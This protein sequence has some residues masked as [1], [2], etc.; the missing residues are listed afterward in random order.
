MTAVGVTADGSLEVSE[1]A[2]LDAAGHDGEVET[3]ADQQVNEQFTP[4]QAV[5]D[6]DGIVEPGGDGIHVKLSIG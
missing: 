3:G 1:E 5:A 6:G 4:D 2:E